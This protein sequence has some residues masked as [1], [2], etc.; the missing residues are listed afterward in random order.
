VRG[1]AERRRLA[2]SEES[3]SASPDPIPE[4]RLTDVHQSRHNS[5]GNRIPTT[6]SDDVVIGI[7]M[8]PVLSLVLEGVRF[9]TVKELAMKIIPLLNTLKAQVADLQLTLSVLLSVELAVKELKEGY[10]LLER[11]CGGCVVHQV[12]TDAALK[13]LNQS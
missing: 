3:N 13:V 5:T 6:L 7:G 10:L 2:T 1:R 11:K 8:P 9:V 12:K 4:R